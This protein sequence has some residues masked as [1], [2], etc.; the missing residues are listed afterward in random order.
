M[1]SGGIKSIDA[2]SL[3]WPPWDAASQTGLRLRDDFRV[4]PNWNR[5]VRTLSLSRRRQSPLFVFFR[6]IAVLTPSFRWNRY[7]STIAMLIRKKATI[8][9]DHK[10][11]KTIAES[12]GEEE[13]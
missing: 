1:T 8:C 6:W 3:D 10:R 2:L 5:I 12:F 11:R 7:Q 4:G 9:I 13:L